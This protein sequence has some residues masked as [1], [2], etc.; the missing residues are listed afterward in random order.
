V[1]ATDYLGSESH[2]GEGGHKEARKPM[3]LS[4]II[5]AYNEEGNIEGTLRR[6]LA[7]LRTQVDEFEI[8]VVDDA[9]TDSTETIADRLAAANPRI[10]VIHN[11]RNLGQGASLV[12]G[13]RNAKHSLVIHNAMDYPFDLNDLGK[14][15]NL[16]PDADIV[17][18]TRACRTGYSLYRRI[19][20]AANV[21]LLNFLFGLGLKDYNFVQLYKREVLGAVPMDFQ[22][23]GFLTPGILICASDLGFKI[24][25]VQ[26]DYLPRTYGKA[27]SGDPRVIFRSVC[28]I[29]RFWRQRRAKT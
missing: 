23:T 2:S 27:T 10:R 18:A 7:A 24:R 11:P 25:E 17:V 5:P 12:I 14:M 26:V 3:N 6:S 21:A 4:V 16:L 1:A 13:F 9:S 29:F 15:L 28:D 19:V 8:I 22:A 20:S